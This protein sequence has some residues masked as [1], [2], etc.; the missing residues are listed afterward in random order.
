M[1]RMAAF[2]LW[3]GGIAACVLTINAVHAQQP[4]GDQPG[5][6]SFSR[7]EEAMRN[8]YEIAAS[9]QTRDW[10][11]RQS[12][13]NQALRAIDQALKDNP[14]PPFAVV[15]KYLAPS[16][17]MLVNDETGFHYLGFSLKRE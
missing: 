1:R 11:G 8:L 5:M 13:N 15:Q 4:G 12:G 6:I 16:G 17:S 3:L 9:Q 7:P 10:L 14:L 2:T